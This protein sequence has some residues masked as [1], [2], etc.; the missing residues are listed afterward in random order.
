MFMIGFFLL[1]YDLGKRRVEKFHRLLCNYYYYYFSEHVVQRFN[2]GHTPNYVG[3]CT[4][5]NRKTA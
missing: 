5:V 4:E 3:M 1:F 2:Y